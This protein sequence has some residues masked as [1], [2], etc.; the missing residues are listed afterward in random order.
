MQS[1]RLSIFARSVAIV[2]AA[3]TTLALVSPA[4]ATD[5]EVA[6]SVASKSVRKP[7]TK[8]EAAANPKVLYC[9]EGTVTGSRIQRKTCHTRQ[10][11]IARTGIDPIEE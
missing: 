1:N 10:D 2:G 3:A 6:R 11:W 7:M 4:A 5:R 9:V 8:A